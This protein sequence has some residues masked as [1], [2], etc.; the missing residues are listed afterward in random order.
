MVDVAEV[1]VV[2]QA[3]LLQEVLRAA[4]EHL[5]T[6]SAGRRQRD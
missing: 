4:A 3:S 5:E 6:L 2:E 1:A